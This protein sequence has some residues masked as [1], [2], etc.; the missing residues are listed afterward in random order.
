MRGQVRLDRAEE[1]IIGNQFEYA[2]RIEIGALRLFA[3]QGTGS[4][5]GGWFRLR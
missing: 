1:S 4:L 2:V 5:Q 3:R